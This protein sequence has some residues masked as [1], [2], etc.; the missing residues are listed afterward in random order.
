MEH[1]QICRC[2][3]YHTL[4]KK[5]VLLVE[6]RCSYNGVLDYFHIQSLFILYNSGFCCK[7]KGTRLKCTKKSRLLLMLLWY[8]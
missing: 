1:S 7:P 8:G 4:R 5:G 3:K 2:A 6:R